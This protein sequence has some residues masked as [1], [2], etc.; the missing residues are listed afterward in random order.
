[1]QNANLVLTGNVQNVQNRNISLGMEQHLG[2]NNNSVQ[3]CNAVCCGG[4][5]TVN[6]EWYYIRKILG[7]VSV[8]KRCTNCTLCI[9]HCALC[10][11]HC[12]AVQGG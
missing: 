6:V 11:V 8:E 1:M 12:A 4:W 3:K 10:I 2:Q 9:V 5:S 7:Y